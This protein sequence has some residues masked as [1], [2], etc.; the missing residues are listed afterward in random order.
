MEEMKQTISARVPKK[1]WMQ[2]KDLQRFW[3]LKTISETLERC[4]DEGNTMWMPTQES[5]TNKP[6]GAKMKELTIGKQG[7]S[8]K[9]FRV[10]VTE[11]R[12]YEGTVSK[13][14]TIID[15]TC[16]QTSESI[17]NNIYKSQ[18]VRK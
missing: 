12:S 11:D 2:L 13:Q 3:N 9:L 18:Q 15:F 17:L 16:N 6:T 10:K 14:F 7:S 4:I 1:E 5:F 8:F